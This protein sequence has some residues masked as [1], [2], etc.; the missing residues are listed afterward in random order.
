VASEVFGLLASHPL[1]AGLPVGALVPSARLLT[2][3]AGQLL[4]AEGDPAD[5]IYLLQRGRV[6]L[7]LHESG[8]GPLVIET[9]GAGRIVGLS[10]I[11]PPFRWHFD[12]RAVE[13]VTAIA[14][15]AAAVRAAAAADPAFGYALMVRIGAVMLERLHATRVRL[16]DIYGHGGTR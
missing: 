6:A 13:P 12:A 4:M 3:E 2:V 14:L 7:E 5:T 9:V 8:R 11:A 1:L 16:L 15:D 10:W